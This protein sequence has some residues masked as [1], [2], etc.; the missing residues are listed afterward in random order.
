MWYKK[1]DIHVWFKNGIAQCANVELESVGL[2]GVR[3]GSGGKYL[4]FLCK[5]HSCHLHF[6]KMSEN[7][8]TISFKYM[9]LY[10]NTI[11]KLQYNK[12]NKSEKNSFMHAPSQT[13]AQIET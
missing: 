7:M 3:T 5:K 10:N 12:C 11:I 9:Y 8:R 6:N 13:T 4:L 1:S 2:D